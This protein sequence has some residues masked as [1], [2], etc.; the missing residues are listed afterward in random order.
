M[1]NSNSSSDGIGFCGMLFI[2]FLVLKLCGVITW[3]WLWILSPL[4]IPFVFVST[5]AIIVVI[6]AVLLKVLLK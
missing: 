1:S 6:V 4:W 2:A 5:L 3:S